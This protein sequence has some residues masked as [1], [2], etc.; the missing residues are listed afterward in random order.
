MN[1]QTLELIQKPVRC[2]VVG[3]EDAGNDAHRAVLAAVIRGQ[4]HA[5]SLVLCEPSQAKNTTRPPDVVLVC[6]VAGVHVMEGN[7]DTVSRHSGG[8]PPWNSE[9]LTRR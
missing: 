6:P 1:A 2:Q 4:D 7:A 3:W 8:F 5:E 9:L